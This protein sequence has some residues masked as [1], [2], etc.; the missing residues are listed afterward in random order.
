MSEQ[1]TAAE[2]FYLNGSWSYQ[3]GE[4]TPDEGRR[5]C[6]RAAAMAERWASEAGIEFYWSED[7]DACA[8]AMDDSGDWVQLGQLWR[9]VAIDS[10]G[11]P[12]SSLGGVDFASGQP[13]GE[14]YRRVVEA[15]LAHEAM[16]NTDGA[17]SSLDFLAIRNAVVG[18]MK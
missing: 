4:Q 7:N 18:L 10:N 9:C 15:E 2:F 1:L 6:A 5:E 17:A 11:Q 3:P 16:E 8:D 14:S 12:L 13:W